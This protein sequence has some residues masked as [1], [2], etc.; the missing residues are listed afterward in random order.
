[1]SAEAAL[2]ELEEQSRKQ[3]DPEIARTFIRLPTLIESLKTYS[4]GWNTDQE[5]VH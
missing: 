4:R 3:F 5:R 1:M 2:A